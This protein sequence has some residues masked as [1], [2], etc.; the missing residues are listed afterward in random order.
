MTLQS[1]PH[2]MA[3]GGR[4][5]TL[6][7]ALA[8]AGAAAVSL[9]QAG[10][11]RAAPHDQRSRVGDICGST[12]GLEPGQAQYD[13]CLASLSGSLRG[14]SQGRA[15]W[16]AHDACLDEGLKPGSPDLAVCT[17]QSIKAKSSGGSATALTLTN[18]SAA[19]GA[20]RSYFSVSN[21]DRFRREQLGCA[22]LGLDPVSGAFDS[23][24][25]G[26]RSALFAA[27]NPS[28]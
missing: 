5:K 19:R 1:F 16:A 15:A 12:V 26:L 13:A 24:V 10:S 27:D 3:Q 14:L 28:Q 2:A 4:A 8:L 21:G 6:A 22:Q 17:L 9:G 20:I 18:T 7:I 23:C 25:A 11:A